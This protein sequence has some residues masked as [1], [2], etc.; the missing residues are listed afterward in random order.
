MKTIRLFVAALLGS[1][2]GLAGDSPRFKVVTY[3]VENYLV[4]RSGTRAPKPEAA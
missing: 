4:E 1:L 3:N 2:L